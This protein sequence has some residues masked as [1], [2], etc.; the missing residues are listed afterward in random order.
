MKTNPGGEPDEPEIRR[1]YNF[2]GG[3]RGKFYDRY[4]QGTKSVLFDPPAV[5]VPPGLDA[6]AAMETGDVSVEDPSDE[7]GEKV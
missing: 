7:G 5:D 2:R 3:V 6:E 4:T 1:E